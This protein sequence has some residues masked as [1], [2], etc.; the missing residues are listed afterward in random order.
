MD[1]EC[2][3]CGTE[4]DVCHDDGF[5]YA[6]DVKH[7]MTCNNCDKHFVFT[8]S[9]YFRYYPSSA[10]CLNGEKH[11]WK[12]TITFPKEYTRMLCTLCGEDRK[13]TDEEMTE[14]LKPIR[15]V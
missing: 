1:L 4:Q 11:I 8:T 5:G 12:P 15:D 3:Y 10:D 7:Q 6:E 9:K 14:I 2:P 13:P